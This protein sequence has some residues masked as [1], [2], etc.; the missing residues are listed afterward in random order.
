MLFY[1]A[2]SAAAAESI[3]S[4][5]FRNN[6]IANDVAASIPEGVYFSDYPLDINSGTKG[7]A[8]LVIE[9]PEGEIVANHEL[10]Y[11]NWSAYREFIIPADVVNSYAL[12][13]LCTEDEVDRAIDTA[14]EKLLR[15]LEIEPGI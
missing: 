1:H 11:D 10:A 6:Q 12:P 9:M 7:S 3:L 5:G 2:T 13:R 14:S 4:R 8:T 15:E